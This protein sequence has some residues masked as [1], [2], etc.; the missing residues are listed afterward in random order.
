ML[1][2]L[3][4]PL[5]KLRLNRGFS[6]EGTAIMLSVSAGNVRR[7]EQGIIIPSFFQLKD[8]AYLYKVDYNTLIP[9]ILDSYNPEL[10]TKRRVAEQNRKLRK[11]SAL[12]E[13]DV[14]IE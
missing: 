7:W 9:A 6:I 8:I 11:K 1:N 14:E 4:T 12:L 5:K 2:P 3:P 13:K 10:A